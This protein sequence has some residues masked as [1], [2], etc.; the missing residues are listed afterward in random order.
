M[1]KSSQVREIN[2]Y[3]AERVKLA[4]S[5]AKISRTNLGKLLDIGYQGL[6]EKETGGAMIR[7]AEIAIIARATGKPV[8]WFF[9]QEEKWTEEN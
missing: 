2:K 9:P 4:R 6:Y 8:E 7:A 1:R 5:E 3:I